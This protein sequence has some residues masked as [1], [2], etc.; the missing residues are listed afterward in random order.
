MFVKMKNS[1]DKIKM[2]YCNK[3][4]ALLINNL[5]INNLLINN[6]LINNIFY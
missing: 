5:L 6:L 3:I 2:L 4:D 1:I